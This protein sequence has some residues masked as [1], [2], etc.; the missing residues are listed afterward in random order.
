L[1][2]ADSGERLFQVEPFCGILSETALDAAD[3]AEFLHQATAF[4]NDRLWGTLNATLI[5]PPRL[6]AGSVGAAVAQ[7]VD[8]LRYGAVGINHW[9]ALVYATVSPPWGG[10]PSATL[11]NIQSG[12]GWV[13]NT[14]LLGGIEK[15]IVRGPT[16][17]A[18]KPAWYY[19]NRQCDVIGRRLAA[20]ESRPR[21]LSLPP[22][23]LAALRG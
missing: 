4:C 21:V 2:S 7:A 15:S 23:V 17:L 13:H 6:E 9:P 10:H 8:G 12:L 3:P 11:D 18:P 19:D 14:Y 1:D 16:V 22:L 20:F 5:V